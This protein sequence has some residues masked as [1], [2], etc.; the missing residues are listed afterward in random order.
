MQYLFQASEGQMELFNKA[1]P[2]PEVLKDERTPPR[3]RALL[4]E[5]EPIKRFGESQ[6][7]RPTPNYRDY[8][9]L[10]RPAVV[11]V[12][13]A[14]EPLRFK[15]KEWS[16]P[17]V[18]SFP[19]LGWFDLPDARAY[20]SKLAHQGY[21]VD[22][23]GAG[24]YSTL[25]WFSDPV[26]STM[27]PPG[28]EALGELVNV[29]LHEST[30]ATVYINGQSYF[31]ESLANFVAD[32]MTPQY[33]KARHGEDKAALSAYLGAERDYGEAEQALH[34]AYEKLEKLYAS[35]L[36]DQEKLEEKRRYLSELRRK[37]GFRRDINNATLIQYRT[38]NAGAKG[39]E[40]LYQACGGDWRRFLRSVS[41]LKPGSFSMPQ[42]ESLGPVLRPLIEGGCPG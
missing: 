27:I 30:H 10:D 19:Y 7:L 38:Y 8:V 32:R 14:S 13:T 41:R 24:A 12:V 42:Q 37:L 6:G 23:R 36:S 35:P 33:L 3:I 40:A 21:D 1:R 34:G 28:E 22:V 5:V 4:A 2:I 25:G 31:D 16:F 39:F 9:K 18:G 11:W 20:A 17:I 15:A 26:L 29:I